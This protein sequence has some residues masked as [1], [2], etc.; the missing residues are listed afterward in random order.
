MSSTLHSKSQKEAG[1][2]DDEFDNIAQLVGHGL[3]QIDT[4][5]KAIR[6]LWLFEDKLSS[7]WL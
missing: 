3:S 1:Q 6:G 7:K 5:S 2:V 4:F